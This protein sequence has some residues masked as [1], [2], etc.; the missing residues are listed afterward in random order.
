MERVKT[1]HQVTKTIFGRKKAMSH[2][3][4]DGFSPSAY[5]MVIVKIKHTVD[6]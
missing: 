1:S 4:R 6:S 2:H 3:E 5:H